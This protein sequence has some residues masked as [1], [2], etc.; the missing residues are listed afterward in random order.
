[1]KLATF[2]KWAVA[3][4]ALAAGS[5][6]AATDVAKVKEVLTANACLA[7]HAMDKK[8]VG[9]SYMDIGAKY[10][11]KEGDAA[12]LAANIRNGVSGLWGPIPMPANKNVSDADLK[13]IVDWI[14]AGAPAQ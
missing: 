3:A 4:S 6:Y 5:A 13:L 9:P 8:V 1:M 14:I 12:T 7:C 11:G 2:L 10:K